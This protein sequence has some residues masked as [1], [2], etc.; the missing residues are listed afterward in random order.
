MSTVQVVMLKSY[1]ITVKTLQKALQKPS[2][3]R[4]AA[5][6]AVYSKCYNIQSKPEAEAT[7]RLLVRVRSRS[8]FAEARGLG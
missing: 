2:T 6:H 3:D 5:Y 8:E 4:F 7:S 1:V